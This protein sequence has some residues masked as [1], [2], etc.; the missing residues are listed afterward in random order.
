[1]L[2]RN[3]KTLRAYSAVMVSKPPGR[4]SRGRD[5]SP[6]K[7]M[8]TRRYP[9]PAFNELDDVEVVALTALDRP[10]PD[11]EWLVVANE[12]V[13]FDLLP[14]LRIVANFGVGYDRIDVTA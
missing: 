2:P 9:W 13:P 8:T 4:A 11:V 7:V 14:N 12:P 6:V 3:Y 10:R 1:M 5:T